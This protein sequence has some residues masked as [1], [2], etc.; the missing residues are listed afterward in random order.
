MAS[1]QHELDM[2]SSKGK[3]LLSELNKIPDCDFHTIKKEMDTLVDQWLDVSLTSRIGMVLPCYL[4]LSLKYC[5]LIYL[6]GI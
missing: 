4:F 3:Q 6:S 1:K 2:F 5:I